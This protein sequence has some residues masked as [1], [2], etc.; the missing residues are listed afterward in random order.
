M[1]GLGKW[2]PLGIIAL[3]L[4]ISGPSMLLAW[5]KLRRRNLGPILDANGWAINSRARINVSFGA[6]MTELAAIPKH[7]KRLLA[8][9]FADKTPPFRL[10]FAT[11]ALLILAGTWYVGRLD[12]YLPGFMKSTTVMGKSA[13]AYKEPPPKEVESGARAAK[14]EPAA[15]GAAKSEAAAVGAAKSEPAAVVGSP[16]VSAPPG[17]PVAT[18]TT[19]AANPGATPK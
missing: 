15:V 19:P 8:D 4:M 12:G 17:A 13:P 16:P 10:Y 7:S 14:S 9:P 2:L 6:A 18:P 11:A 1:F 5:L 3:L